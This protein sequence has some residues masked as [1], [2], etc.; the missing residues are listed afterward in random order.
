MTNPISGAY[1]A[2]DAI[3]FKDC[4]VEVDVNAESD[5]ADIDSWATEIAV[6]GED[7]P[8]TQTY[9]FEGSAIVF[10]G[11]KS[12][13]TINCT[14]VYTEG[15]DDPFHNVRAR[16]EAAPGGAFDI[17]FAPAGSG[18]GNK[19]FTTSGGKLTAC[20]LPVGAGDASTATVSTFTVVADSIAQGTM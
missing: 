3:S 8:F 20:P 7:V 1:A 11:N 14:I 13:V 2:G 19:R 10:T 17:R 4:F 18:A 6:S 16:F 5:W 9:P 15:T 12:P